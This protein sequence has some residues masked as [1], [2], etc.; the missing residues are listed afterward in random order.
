[1]L[2]ATAGGVLGRGDMQAAATR[3]Q[4]AGYLREM[5]RQARETFGGRAVEAFKNVAFGAQATPE[6]QSF[7][8][9]RASQSYA[10]EQA[11][12]ALSGAGLNQG[13]LEAFLAQTQMENMRE[14]VGLLKNVVQNTAAGASGFPSWGG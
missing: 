8:G 5:E 13:P 2:R 10:P 9:L 14:T 3:Q 12:M 1:L 7:A 6:L 4:Q 11:S